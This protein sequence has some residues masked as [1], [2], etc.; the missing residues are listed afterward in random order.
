MEVHSLKK[1]SFSIILLFRSENADPYFLQQDYIFDVDDIQSKTFRELEFLGEEIGKTVSKKM[2]HKYWKYLLP[3]IGPTAILVN[4]EP[5]YRGQGYKDNEVDNFI[6][7]KTELRKK[8]LI[9]FAPDLKLNSKSASMVNSQEE[10]L[11]PY[12]L[13]EDKPPP[14]YQSPSSNI[15]VAIIY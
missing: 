12:Q 1:H 7:A 11:P 6:R 5:R 14:Y 13:R 4:N 9:P 10:Q 8:L 15:P 2:A 3:V